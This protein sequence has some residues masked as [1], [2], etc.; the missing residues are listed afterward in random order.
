[1]TLR[2]MQMVCGNQAGAATI[3]LDEL[4]ENRELSGEEAPLFRARSMHEVAELLREKFDIRPR[5]AA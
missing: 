4:E 2:C 1:M 5:Q 3:L